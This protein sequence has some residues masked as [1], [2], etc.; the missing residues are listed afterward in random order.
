MKDQFSHPY[1]TA[2]RIMA[3][4]ILTFALL[5]SGREDKKLLIE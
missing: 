3:F 1:K 5:D 4:Y 2:D